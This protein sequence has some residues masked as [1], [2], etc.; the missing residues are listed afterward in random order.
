MAKILKV[1]VVITA[2][3]RAVRMKSVKNKH[4]ME[5]AGKPILVHSIEAFEKNKMINEIIL[6]STSERIKEYE[7]LISK[8]KL[9]KVKKI[10]VGGDERQKS[11]FNGLKETSPDS[12][13]VLIH[14][15]AN[16]LVTQ[17][18]IEDCISAS[19]Q[20]GAAV[21]GIPEKN[22]IKVVEENGFVIGTLER[23][24]LYAVQTP[25][26]MK[27][28]IAL[29]AFAKA[30]LEQFN[31]TDDVQLVERLGKRVKL[32]IGN[33]KNFKI[34]TLED[35]VMAEAILRELGKK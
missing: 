9:K 31:G 6:V 14:N 15:G 34:T 3:G 32:V 23:R 29:E 30:E 17:K 4:L 1:S 10:V 20:V 16:P 25:Q 7:K 33:Y 18:E 21:V 24:K 35:L 27:R 11:V 12:E 5:L 13:I 2:A 8:Y 22:T 19:K 28:E 26:G